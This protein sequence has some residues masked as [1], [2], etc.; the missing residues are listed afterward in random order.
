MYGG[1]SANERSSLLMLAQLDLGFMF[2]RNS[3]GTSRSRAH[4]Q[5]AGEPIDIE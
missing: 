5:N 4:D 2:F 3:T 1:Y